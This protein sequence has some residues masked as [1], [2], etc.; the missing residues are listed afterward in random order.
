M[1]KTIKPHFYLSLFFW[2]LFVFSPV[3]GQEQPSLR[4]RAD[5]LYHEYQYAKAAPIY[6]K[7]VEGKKPF[8]HDFERLADSYYKM[9][10]YQEAEK[11]YAELAKHKDSGVENLL[12]YAK[13]LKQNS[14]YV[15]A[16]N[17]FLEYAEKTGDK[18]AVANEI[19]G[20]DSALVWIANPTLHTLLNEEGINTERS[21]FSAYPI[22]GKVYFASESNSAESLQY[23][24]TGNPFLN[25]Y[26]VDNTH[27][28][29]LLKDPV[30][31]E[32]VNNAEY[33]VGPISSSQDG[34][35]LYV[36]RTYVV[37]KGQTEKSGERNY[38]TNRLGIV[39]FQKGENGEWT[40][41]EFEHNLVEEYSV[42]HA[43]LSIDGNTLYFVSD[44]PGGIGGTDIWYSEKQRDGNWGQP[45]NAGPNINTPKDELFPNIAADGTLYYSSNGLPGMGG[46]DIFSSTGSKSSWSKAANLKYPIN[47]AGDDFAFVSSSVTKRGIKGYLSSNRQGGKGGDDIY[48]FSYEEPIVYVEPEIILALRG[49]VY[50][51]DTKEVLP[52]ALVSLYDGDQQLIAKQSSGRDGSVFFELEKEVDYRLVGEKHNHVGDFAELTT[53]GIV[54]SDTLF[55]S[56]YLEPIFVVGKTYTLENIHYDFDKHNIRKDAAEILDGLLKTLNENPTLKIELA[57]HTDSRGSDSYNKALSQRRAQAAVDYLVSRGIAR[58]RMVAMGYGET[59]LLNE[60]AN[61]VACSDEAHQANR[62]TEFTVLEF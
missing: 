5:R 41:R 22:G 54:K 23:G 14:S 46:L 7:L 56:L 1:N 32:L 31:A 26:T 25:L 48:S 30:F 62:R 51:K 61:G 55:A 16:K 11:W 53:K 60:C 39:V 17:V 44:R 8:L 47:S 3:Y 52:E 24:W 18:L 50:N 20:C 27:G 45:V 2:A 40:H 58:D 6:L 15:E 33:H 42:G 36:T 10:R 29:D 49:L 13:V 19:A 38:L 37:D 34:N 21:E 4:E 9:N 43:T 57:S 35:T 12:I 59:R 28:N